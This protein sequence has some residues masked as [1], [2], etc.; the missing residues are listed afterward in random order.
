M[1]DSRKPINDGYH[2]GIE[3]RG[4]QPTQ[5]PNNPPSHSNPQNGYRPETGK[6]T[7]ASNPPGDE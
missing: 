7:P 6:Q 4:Y 3:K 5:K 1:V 2:P